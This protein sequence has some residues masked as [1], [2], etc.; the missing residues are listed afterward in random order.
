M[1]GFGLNRHSR[2]CMEMA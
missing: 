1:T 2:S